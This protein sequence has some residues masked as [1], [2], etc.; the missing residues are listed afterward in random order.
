[1]HISREN[2]ILRHFLTFPVDFIPLI[3]QT[4]TIT[5]PKRRQRHKSHKTMPGSSIPVLWSTLKTRYLRIK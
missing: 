4:K 2:A 1:M 5:Q 3:K